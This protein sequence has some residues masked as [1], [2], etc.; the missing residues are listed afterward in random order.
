MELQLALVIPCYNEASRKDGAIGFLKRLQQLQNELDSNIYKYV[1]LIDDGSTDDTKKILQSFL[2]K[3]EDTRILFEMLAFPT[4]QGKGKALLEGLSVACNL[5]EAIVYTD[6]DLSIPIS[7]LNTILDDYK[8]GTVLC[9]TRIYQQ[10]QQIGR[11]ILS[12]LAR[13]CNR[14]FLGIP[15]MDTQ[16]PFKLIPSKD[17][18]LIKNQLVGYRWLFDIELLWNLNQIGIPFLE[19]KILFSNMDSISLHT[20]KAMQVC[21]KDFFHFFYHMCRKVS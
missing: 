5:S 1:L 3:K 20:W 11:R 19:R 15:V 18:Q 7:S 21:L 16:C 12:A 13:L 14:V 10:K 8:A 9:G 6:A 2:C 4:N 17:F